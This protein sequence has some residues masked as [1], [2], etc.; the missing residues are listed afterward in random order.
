M[1]SNPLYDTKAPKKV[2]NLSVNCDLLHKTRLNNI[3]LSDI[4]EERLIEL[5]NEA[6]KKNWLNKNREAIDE[7]NKKVERDY[8]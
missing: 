5:L 2:I 1:K 4:L 8:K 6:Q 3:N 7:Y